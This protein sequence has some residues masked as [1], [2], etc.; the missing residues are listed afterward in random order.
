MCFVKTAIKINCML[1]AK[2]QLKLNLNNKFTLAYI[3]IR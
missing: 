2:M 3:F 1:I